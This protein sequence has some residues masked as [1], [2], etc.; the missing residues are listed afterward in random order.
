MAGGILLQSAATSGNGNVADLRGQGGVHTLSVVGAG[1]TITAGELQW[2]HALTSDY[3]G[4]WAPLGPPI[5]PLVGAM[6]QQSFEGPLHFVRARITT[7]VAGTGTPSVSV[8][9]QPPRV[10]GG[11]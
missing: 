11:R 5:T 6:V 9:V 1:S 10:L 2:E 8:R 3:S 4:T 7:T